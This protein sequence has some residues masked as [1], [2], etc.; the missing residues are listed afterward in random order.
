MGIGIGIAITRSPYRL[1]QPQSRGD[2]GVR[3]IKNGRRRSR[4]LSLILERF[5]SGSNCISKESVK[6]RGKDGKN[7]GGNTGCGRMDTYGNVILQSGT[8]ICHYT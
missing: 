7:D 2:V 3:T 4:Q 6:L 5:G 1:S 8:A